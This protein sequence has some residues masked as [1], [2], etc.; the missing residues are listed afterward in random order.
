VSDT[1]VPLVK[2]R[3]GRFALAALSGLLMTL[4]FP[5]WDLH[6]LILVAFVPLLIALEGAG[7]RLTWALATTTG[8][9]AMSAGRL[10][11]IFT[12]E[13]FMG[14]PSPASYLVWLAMALWSAQA[15]ALIFVSAAWAQENTRLPLALWLPLCGAAL[16]QLFPDIFIYTLSSS[17]W[18]MRTLLQ[19]I[20]WTGTLG[21]DFVLLLC[22][23]VVYAAAR[24][25]R[26]HL[27]ALAVGGG[28]VVVAWVVA[29]ALL[30]SS[31]DA[32]VADMK[33]KRV[34]IVQ[35]NRIA[36]FKW[37]DP[38]PGYTRQYPVDMEMSE[39]LAQDGA[40]LIVWPEAH[41]YGTMYSGKTRRAF[42]AAAQEMG[43]DLVIH[44]K[45]FDP[46]LGTKAR[47]N[48]SV[49]FDAEGNEPVH[50]HKRRLV[51]FGEYFPGVPEWLRKKLGLWNPLTPGDAAVVFDAGGM[52][53]QPLICY[54]VVFSNLAG[55]SVGDDGAG[56]VI[57]AQ[58]QDGWY[59]PGSAPEFHRAG[60]VLRAV[61]T[62]TPVVHALN[63]GQSSVIDPTGRY[64][65]LADNLVRGAWNVDMPYDPTSGGS[66]F[67]RHPAWFE[68]GA[69]ALF[70]L[71]VVIVI[72][73]RL[74]RRQQV[75]PAD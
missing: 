53:L 6:A 59:G 47:R 19:P 60:T 41:T 10:W 29:G 73:R 69:Q 18:G 28:V 50:Y 52:R 9:V 8:V 55:S 32:R 35:P 54:E 40:E 27:R 72:V 2:D 65:F 16:W 24:H 30:L 70:G 45:G 74:R 14:V 67:S 61:E 3:R 75:V 51:P 5:S 43:T 64:V 48:S 57:L 25:R 22:N 46:V 15:I 38:E 56:K 49:L 1:T 20:E 12:A 31:W 63:S 68:R 33:T 23:G 66:F 58:S 7:K 42:R 44:D 21:L 4:A 62:R 37:L 71:L 39:R 26:P 13:V 36:T 34:G 17:L 11:L